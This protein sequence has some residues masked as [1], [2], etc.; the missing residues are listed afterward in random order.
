MLP[1]EFVLTTAKPLHHA[2]VMPHLSVPVLVAMLPLMLLWWAVLSVFI[3]G[4]VAAGAVTSLRTTG[5]G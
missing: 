4:K 3:G 5:R 1:N 2:P